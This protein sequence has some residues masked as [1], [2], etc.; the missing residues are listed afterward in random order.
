MTN[1]SGHIAILA[2]PFERCP[3]CGTMNNGESG[4][5][6]RVADKYGMH[7][8]CDVCATRSD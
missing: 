2:P 4:S 7:L 6:W 8:E 5:L 3:K 1:P